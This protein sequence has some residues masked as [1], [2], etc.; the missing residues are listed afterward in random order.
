MATLGVFTSNADGEIAGDIVTLVLRLNRC[1]S[2]PSPTSPRQEPRF[3]TACGRPGGVLDQDQ[4]GQEP[5]PSVR[6]GDPSF[7]QVIDAALV[8]IEGIPAL[9][10]SRSGGPRED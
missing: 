6:L 4:Q 2:A 10:W 8:E 9:V 7:G 5:L 1:R 3:R